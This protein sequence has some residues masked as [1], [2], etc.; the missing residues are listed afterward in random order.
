M[1]A[2]LHTSAEQKERSQTAL[3]L[4]TFLANQTGAGKPR[5]DGHRYVDQRQKKG[6]VIVTVAARSRASGFAMQASL[7]LPD[8][9]GHHDFGGAP[10]EARG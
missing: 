8:G 2:T 9:P 4:I 3:L 6:N 7:G 1:L 5:A 10:G